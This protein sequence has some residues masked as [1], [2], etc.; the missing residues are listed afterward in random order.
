MVF[1]AA[2]LRRFL[3]QLDIKGV[4]SFRPLGLIVRERMPRIWQ[5]AATLFREN[6]SV[7]IR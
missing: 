7:L 4:I 3:R 1:R 2:L 6:N 5:V